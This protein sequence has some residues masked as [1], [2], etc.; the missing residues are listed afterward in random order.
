MGTKQYGFDPYYAAGPVGYGPPVG[1]A[2]AVASS[3]GY[4][5]YDVGQGSAFATA[6]SF[7]RKLRR[8]LGADN[9]KCGGW[10]CGGGYYGGFGSPCGGGWGGWGGGGCGGGFGGGFS[11]SSAAARAEAGS[12][13]FGGPFGGSGSAASAEAVASS[14]SFGGKK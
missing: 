1:N 8:L 4:T 7:G 12:S 14:N 13:G 11:S 6:N 3:N 5:T 9:I 10:G 2:V